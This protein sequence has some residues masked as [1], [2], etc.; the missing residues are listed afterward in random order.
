MEAVRTF[1]L[2]NTSWTLPLVL[3]VMLVGGLFGWYLI[4]KGMF[5]T[6]HLGATPLRPVRLPLQP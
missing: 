6:E 1:L 4:Y 2:V 3:G 5:P